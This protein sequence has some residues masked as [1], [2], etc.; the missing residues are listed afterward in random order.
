MINILE[1]GEFV[2]ANDGYITECPWNCKCPNGVNSQPEGAI[3]DQGQRSRHE[4]FNERF[5][6]E[7]CMNGKFRYYVNKHGTCFNCVALLTQ[8]AIEHGEEVFSVAYN[9][10][11]TDDNIFGLI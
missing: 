8:L 6:N 2:E 4:Q 9:D 5:K 3:S 7:G 11:L 1:D 10:T